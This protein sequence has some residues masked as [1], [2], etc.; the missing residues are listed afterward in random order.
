[1]VSLDVFRPLVC[2]E[3]G[4]SFIQG[5]TGRPRKVCYQETCIQAREARKDARKIAR[6]KELRAAG[7]WKAHVRQT[8]GLGKGPV[9]FSQEE[10]ECLKCAHVFKVPADTDWRIC[11]KCHVANNKLLRECEEEALGINPSSVLLAA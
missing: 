9:R 1:M 4:I 7:H 5:G 3:C 8:K 2:E 10:R 11:P 6:K